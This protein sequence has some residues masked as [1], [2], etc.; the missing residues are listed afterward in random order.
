MATRQRFTVPGFTV[1]PS[2]HQN[3]PGAENRRHCSVPVVPSPMSCDRV[4]SRKNSLCA[5]QGMKKKDCLFSPVG[6]AQKRAPAKS[7]FSPHSLAKNLTPALLKTQ[8]RLQTMSAVSTDDSEGGVSPLW[9]YEEKENEPV[10]VKP[11]GETRSEPVKTSTGPDVHH[12]LAES[13]KFTFSAEAGDAPSA[14]LTAPQENFSRPAAAAADAG[15]AAGPVSGK[16]TFSDM[17]RSPEASPTRAKRCNAAYTRCFPIPAEER[18]SGLT[19]VF[20][21]VRLEDFG[22]SGPVQEPGPASSPLGVAK[23]LFCELDDPGE[24]VFLLDRGLE[25]SSFTSDQELCRNLSLDSDGSLNEISVLVG[26]SPASAEPSPRPLSAAAAAAAAAALSSPGDERPEASKAF[27]DPTPQRPALGSNLFRRGELHSPF[28]GRPWACGAASAAAAQSPCFLKPK[29]VVAFRSYC[30]SINR[31]NVSGH[32]L[33]AME[34]SAMASF[35]SVTAAVTPVQKRLSSSSSLYQTPQPMTPSHT[36]FRTPKSVR[37][38]PVPAEGA[39]IL[40]TP[41]YLAPELLLGTPHDFA[42][43]WWA[44]GVCLFE[45]LTGVPPFNDETPQL[46]F[47]NILNGDI[48]WPEEEEELSENARNAIEMLLTKDLAKR[49]GFK[50]LRGHPLF[51][52]LDWDHIQDLAMPFVPQ[53]EDETDTSYFEARNQAQHLAVSGFSL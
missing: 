52:G 42:V 35:C 49:A 38:G 14:R 21:T 24:E 12:H 23:N 32:S 8:R 2:L 20:S 10:G 9:E 53:P 18:H 36:P 41:D 34:T 5:L 22:S 37:R 25:N 19:G 27:A 15:Q 50:E 16:R 47:Q 7:V 26:N 30:S 48:P 44:L 43:D 29:S 45:F 40:G 1:S 11:E 3:T 13:D 31:S 17:E 4:E 46:V 51:E 6:Y 39:Q 28:P 33:D